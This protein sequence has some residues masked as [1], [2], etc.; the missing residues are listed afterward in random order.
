MIARMSNPSPIVLYGIPNCG[1]VKK[2]RAW[3]AERGVACTF[4]DFRKSGVSALQ[5][6]RW[7]DALGWEAL[8]NRRGTTWRRLDAAT[9]AGVIDQASACALMQAQ[10]SLIKRPVVEWG[11]AVT[12]GF[13]EADWMRRCG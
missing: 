11:G 2:A 8:L 7:A 4:H 3:L 13:D 12:V 6:R 5:L 10:P 9:Q 1:T